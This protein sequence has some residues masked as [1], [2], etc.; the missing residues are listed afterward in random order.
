MKLVYS[1]E[2]GK[3]KIGII[4]QDSEIRIK[5]QKCHY[6]HEERGNLSIFYIT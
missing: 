4:R 5:E 1:V 2:E 6:D 3:K